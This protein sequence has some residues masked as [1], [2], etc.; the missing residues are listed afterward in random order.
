MAPTSSHTLDWKWTFIFITLNPLKV[1][2]YAICR[3]D[4]S[5]SPGKQHISAILMH[6]AHPSDMLHFFVMMITHAALVTRFKLKHYAALKELMNG[7]YTSHI[8][9][10]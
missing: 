7:T 9:F 5:R 1:A 8:M 4:A 3:H 10:T 6:H 2:Y